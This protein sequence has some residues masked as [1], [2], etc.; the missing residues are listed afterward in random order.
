[1]ALLRASDA[2][3][4]ACI[5]TLNA[6][7]A[8][9]RL[10][11]AE[12]TLRVGRALTAV[13]RR[14]LAGLLGDLEPRPAPAS[15]SVADPAGDRRTRG[16]LLVVLAAVVLVGFAIAGV[17]SAGTSE[18][19]A[20]GPAETVD[21]VDPVASPAASELHTVDGYRTFVEA[22]R[23]KFGSSTVV[24]AVLYPDYASVTV[25]VDGSPNRVERW[26]YRTGFDDNT[27]QRSTRSS[28]EQVD[29]DLADVDAARLVEHLV[30]APKALNVADSTNRYAIIGRQPAGADV[31]YAIY[32]S[33][34]YSE[35]GYWRFTLDGREQDRRPF[36]TF[37][38]QS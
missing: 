36:A 27:V 1:M 37:E 10:T 38:G 15:S 29:V 13:T 31:G 32:V 34:E 25:P 12:R 14:D 22:V 3:R 4:D 30:E 24:E 8:D 33:N 7:F 5:E 9:G 21:V 26:Y 18:G 17:L 6:A 23:E 20:G 19:E 11:D 28:S 2:D 35:S 16:L